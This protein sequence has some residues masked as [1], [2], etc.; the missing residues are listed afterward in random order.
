MTELEFDPVWASTY[1]QDG[2]TYIF[3]NA[4][5]TVDT[6]DKPQYDR[7][8]KIADYKERNE[9]TTR[10]LAPGNYHFSADVEFIT[11][12]VFH[13][14]R[15]TVFQIHDACDE[16]REPPSMLNI[17][18]GHFNINLFPATKD[19]SSVP[20]ELKF[21]LKVDVEYTNNKAVSVDYYINND[22]IGSTRTINCGDI[23]YIKFGLYRI[24]GR[25]DIIQKY[26]N[27]TCTKE[28][29]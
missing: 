10:K 17:V 4:K 21:N 23:L 7:G 3:Q 1:E 12:I 18:N 15:A 14:H 28:S 16:L 9:V 13:A 8:I 19:Q 29:L 6:D 26:T 25:C 11:P 24:Q 22:Y 27:V 20:A 5:G 2:N